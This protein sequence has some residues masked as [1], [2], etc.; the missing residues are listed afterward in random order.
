MVYGDFITMLIF[1]GDQHCDKLSKC[2]NWY[3]GK[4]LPSYQ[5][6][7]LVELLLVRCSNASLRLFFTRFTWFAEIL[8]QC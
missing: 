3:D 7:H 1:G 5:F 6:S 4:A 2:E 8:S